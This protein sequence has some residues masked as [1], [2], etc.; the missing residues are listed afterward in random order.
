MDEDEVR[1]PARTWLALFT[2]CAVA[3]VAWAWIGA[4]IEWELWDAFGVV[5]AG[6]AVCCLAETVRA[7]ITRRR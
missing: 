2:I 6:C 4:R 5:P 7:A 3:T 1:I